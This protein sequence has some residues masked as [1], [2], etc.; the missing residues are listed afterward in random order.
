V[1]VSASREAQSGTEAPV[2][3]STLSPQVLGGIKATSLEQVLNKVS[4]V[5]M[6]DLGNEQHFMAIRQPISTR[7][8]F[9]YLEDGIPIR[10]SG[11]FNHNALIEINQAALKTIEVIRGPASSLYGSEA[12][13]GAVNFITQA[14]SSVPTASVQAEAGTGGYRHTRLQASGTRGRLGL[15]AGADYA[16]QRDGFRQHSDYH[17]LA[18]TL[19][20]DYQIGER[21]KL[22]ATASLVDYQTDQT[23]G[24][25]VLS[26]SANSIRV[27][28]PSLTGS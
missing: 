18:L 20:A 5:Y 9:L 26:F 12:I 22:V 1:I 2:A 16:W 10:T 13:G 6:V 21:T 14:P 8:V 3:I 11:N 28:T 17:K 23:G 27:S 24:S 7:S 19:R 25:T 15:F 4:G